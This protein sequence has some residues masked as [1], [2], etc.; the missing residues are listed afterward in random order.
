MPEQKKILLNY[1]LPANLE[2]IELLADEVNIALADYADY[3]FPVNLCLDELITNTI[4]YG[5]K[6]APDRTIQIKISATEHFLE[7]QIIDDAPQ[8]HPF[9]NTTQPDLT[10]TI[11]DRKIGGLGIYFVE[12]LMSEYYSH[13]DGHYNVTTLKKLL[14]HT[15]Q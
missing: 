13:H 14:T 3:V 1:R 6:G 10:A 15:K 9:L 5:L 4:T 2:A 8:F 11:E 12:K 7:I